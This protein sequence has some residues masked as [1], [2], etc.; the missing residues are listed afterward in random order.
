MPFPVRLQGST[1]SGTSIFFAHSRI[2]VLRTSQVAK[3]GDLG[4]SSIISAIE[5]TVCWD[6]SECRTSGVTRDGPTE[7]D[8]ETYALFDPVALRE[9]GTFMICF[10]SGAGPGS[11]CKQVHARRRLQ[12]PGWHSQ[13]DRNRD[14]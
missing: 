5:R 13:G 4:S 8:P 3:C 9:V 1:A 10:C 12:H 6:Y 7:F 2:R 11:S 14:E